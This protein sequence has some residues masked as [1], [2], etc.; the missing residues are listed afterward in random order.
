MEREAMGT[1]DKNVTDSLSNVEKETAQEKRA[2]E[3]PVLKKASI[4]SLTK[5]LM[6][7]MDSMEMNS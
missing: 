1:S 4:S 7:G 2:W 3:P 5:K 6:M